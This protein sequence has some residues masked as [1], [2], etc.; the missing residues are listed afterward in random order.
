MRSP[1]CYLN[2]VPWAQGSSKLWWELARKNEK[3][4]PDDFL[5]L[6]TSRFSLCM[7]SSA[8]C[9]HLLWGASKYR[10][11]QR[12]DHTFRQHWRLSGVVGQ[13]WWW[14][15]FFLQ[16]IWN[17]SNLLNTLTIL[18]FTNLNWFFIYKSNFLR[19]Y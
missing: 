17:L 6:L 19:T 10:S 5:R 14:S 12:S 2:G 15:F 1:L 7:L 9:W 13:S 18:F 11:H 8:S 4:D 16:A 3:L